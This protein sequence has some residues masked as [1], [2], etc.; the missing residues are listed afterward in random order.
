MDPFTKRSDG[1]FKDEK[2]WNTEFFGL[3]SLTYSYLVI[4]DDHDKSWAKIKVIKKPFVRDYTTHNEHVN[5][6][7]R[8][9]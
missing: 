2:N 6:L 1:I 7:M 8:S 9:K 5:D 3:R 4:D